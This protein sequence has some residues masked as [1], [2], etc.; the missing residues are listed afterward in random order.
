MRGQATNEFI[1]VLAAIMI[2]FFVFYSLYGNQ[3]INSRQSSE[4]IAAMS[5]AIRIRNAINYVYLAGDGTVYTASYRVGGMNVSIHEG[6]IWAQTSVA[7]YYAPLLTSKINTTS[8]HGG[9]VI[10]KNNKG[11]IEIG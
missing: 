6:V 8:F 9:E 3:W 1:I 4:K 11:L 5:T 7:S 10:I 2:L